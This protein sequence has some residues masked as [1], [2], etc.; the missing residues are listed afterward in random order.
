MNP[1]W[2]NRRSECF[3]HHKYLRRRMSASAEQNLIRTGDNPDITAERRKATFPVGKMS[4]FIH[5]GEEK[6]QRRHEILAFVESV[7]EFQDPIPVEFLSREERIDNNARKA[8]A[9]TDHTDAIDGSD[10]FGEGM[11]Y[12][13]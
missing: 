1:F 6:L 13:R 9:M 12:Q 11:Y 7:P 5:G 2:I 4:A 3:Y 8:V 10:F